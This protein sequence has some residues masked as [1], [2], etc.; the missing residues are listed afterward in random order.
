MSNTEQKLLTAL[1]LIVFIGLVI[2]AA[3]SDGMQALIPT[4]LAI[5]DGELL[6][7]LHPELLPKN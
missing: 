2:W 6:V 1:L 4:I 5:I 7:A 3:V